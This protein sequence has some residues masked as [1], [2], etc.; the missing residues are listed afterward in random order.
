MYEYLKGKLVEAGPQHAIVDVHGIGY[1]LL[2]PVNA[3]S[4]MPEN[5]AEVVLYTSYIIRDTAHALYGFLNRQERDLFELLISV[6]GVGPKIGVSLLGHLGAVDLINAIRHAE[7]A[8]LCKVPGIGK[9]T[10]ERLILE[11]KDKLPIN[12]SDESAN[13]LNEQASSQYSHKIR[14]AMSALINLGYSQA[15]AQK[16]V[17]QTL[18]EMDES[19]ELA[20]LI[21]HA[22]Q[23][24]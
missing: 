3:F 4:R 15:I 21:T 11:I 14:D 16:A 2:L 7:V 20:S 23:R 8:R 10:A 6:S 18:K 13:K 24:C 17:K 9:K 12:S 1:K 22:L 19:A 5:G